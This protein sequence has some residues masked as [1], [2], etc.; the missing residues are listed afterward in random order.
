MPN[1]DELRALQDGAL[2]RC[3]YLQSNWRRRA[4]E[5][6]GRSIVLVHLSVT[7]AVAATVIAAVPAAPKWLIAAVSGGTALATT[8]LAATRT[9]E[10]WVLARSIQ[11]Q[12]GNERFLYEQQA[13]RYAPA[14]IPT[15]EVRVRL[16]SERI[17][18]IARTAHESWAT[19][20]ETT[21]PA[22]PTPP[23]PPPAA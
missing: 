10:H 1:A 9:Q 12:L 3:E 2:A 11:N 20:I 8:L 23:A 5:N 22:V 21:P 17:T 15:G 7:L 19:R 6:K 13:G 14:T 18:E 4:R 16:F